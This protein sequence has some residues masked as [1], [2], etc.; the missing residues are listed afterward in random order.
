M[1]SYQAIR[2]ESRLT[3]QGWTGSLEAGQVLTVG[4]P[5]SFTQ[6]VADYLVEHDALAPTNSVTESVPE[7]VPVP[8]LV[9]E[10]EV[11]EPEVLPPVP[12]EAP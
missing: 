12:E 7:E 6:E 3:A 11:L 8:E 1:G 5:P 4:E 9:P 2:T 10:P